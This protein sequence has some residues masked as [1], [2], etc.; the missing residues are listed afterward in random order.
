MAHLGPVRGPENTR[1][2]KSLTVMG[3]YPRIAVLVT[4]R[5]V[6]GTSPPVSVGLACPPPAR[7]PAA[8]PLAEGA[9]PT[10]TAAHCPPE[11]SQ[12]WYSRDD[13]GGLILEPLASRAGEVAP[14]LPLSG[15]GPHAKDLTL[16]LSAVS[17]APK[18]KA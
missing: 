7:W 5:F 6:T 9:L 10:D 2:L 1:R 8:R 13:A 11:T 16:K 4:S 14:G 18:T 3:L 17:S 15:Q 12:C